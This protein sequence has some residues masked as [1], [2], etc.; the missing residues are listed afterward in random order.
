MVVVVVVVVV[1]AVVVVVVCVCV[2]VVM[3]ELMW[4][5]RIDITIKCSL[6][7]LR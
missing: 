7:Q 6:V 1:V 2:Y 4:A 3:G 5:T